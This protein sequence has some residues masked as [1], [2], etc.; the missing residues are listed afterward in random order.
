MNRD[1][2]AG[3]VIGGSI[4]GICALCYRG[5]RAARATDLQNAKVIG[6][7]EVDTTKD[8]RSKSSLT[9]EDERE[10][11]Q[12]IAQRRTLPLASDVLRPQVRSRLGWT[13]GYFASSVALTAGM[14]ALL[15]K[16]GAAEQLIQTSQT[17]LGRIAVAGCSLLVSFGSIIGMMVIPKRRYVLRHLAYAGFILPMA[18]GASVLGMLPSWHLAYLVL[19]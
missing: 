1:H 8:R 10:L 5:L 7:S 4:A 14:G 13:Y 18:L 9:E 19:H 12:A 16:A 3:I 15:F 17:L 11:Q 2:V 6:V